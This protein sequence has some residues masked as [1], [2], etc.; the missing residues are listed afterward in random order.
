MTNDSTKSASD[1]KPI[2][3]VGTVIHLPHLHKYK[4]W[5]GK[6]WIDITDEMK[7]RA[8]KKI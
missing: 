3:E 4:R 7:E 1:Y 8:K 5:D 6:R 2:I